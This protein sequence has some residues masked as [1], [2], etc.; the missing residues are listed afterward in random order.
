MNGA[1]VQDTESR[2]CNLSK[3]AKNQKR[4]ERKLRKKKV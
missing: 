1:D 2:K 4:L 3:G